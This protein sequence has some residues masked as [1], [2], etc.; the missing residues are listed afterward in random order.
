MGTIDIATVREAA[1]DLALATWYDEALR[2][3]DA[4]TTDDLRDR[5]VLAL[6]AADVADRSDWARGR[7]EASA[8]LE[9]L[10]DA[11]AAYLLEVSE[12]RTP[13]D[14]DSLVWGADWL[15]VRRAYSQA[16]RHDDGSFR[17]GPEGRATHELADLVAEV[18]RVRSTA[19]HDVQ[20][21]W[22][23]VCLGWIC[24][25]LTGERDQAPAHYEAGLAAARDHD[26]ALLLFEAQRHLGDHARDDGDLADARVRWE[27]SAAAGARVRHVGGTLSQQLLLALLLRDE[28]DEAGATAVA[29]E[30]ARW[31]ASIGAVGLHLQA[32]DFLV[33][34]ENR[35]AEDPSGRDAGG[36]TD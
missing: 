6:T 26:D 31:A 10:D 34:Q 15:R 4:T 29:G 17:V 25:N 24:D 1:L 13:G 3:L 11:L 35:S 23:S 5:A 28:G 36:A 30:V 19:G 7:A 12:H 21:G 2:L 16:V 32:T 18:T 20:R 8:R 9:V 14:P 33:E 22:A 27:E